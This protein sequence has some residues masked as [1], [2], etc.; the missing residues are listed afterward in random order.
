MGRAL[1][2][3][4]RVGW[5]SREEH[6]PA[7]AVE[8]DKNDDFSIA[9]PRENRLAAEVRDAQLLAGLLEALLDR[10]LVQD[11]PR[12]QD[13]MRAGTFSSALEVFFCAVSRSHS[14][15]RAVGSLILPRCAS[16]STSSGTG[17]WL[18]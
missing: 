8:L 15:Y 7:V 16:S 13:G 1:L 11:Q 4:L 5:L 3:C 12:F 9:A 18:A 17:A 10:E 2:F 6:W 14:M